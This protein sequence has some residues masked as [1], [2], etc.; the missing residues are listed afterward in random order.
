MPSQIIAFF[1]DGV[2]RREAQRHGHDKAHALELKRE[3]ATLDAIDVDSK[4]E[5][6]L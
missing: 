3:T 6:V 5:P 4:L 1:R 2:L